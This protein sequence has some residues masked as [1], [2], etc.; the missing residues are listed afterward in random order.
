VHRWYQPGTGR[1]TRP[2]PL[3]FDRD[4]HP[5]VYGAGRP[6]F[7]FDP[8]GGSI[9]TIIKD[10]FPGKVCVDKDCNPPA[11]LARKG[12]YIPQLLPL[13]KCGECTTADGLYG[14]AGIWKIRNSGSCTIHCDS[15]GANVRVTCGRIPPPIL[16]PCKGGKQEKPDD[17]WPDNLFCH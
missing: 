10:L 14:R 5:Y 11:D 4:L 16:Y 15:N 2:D 7:F 17:T 9:K 8:D 6:T 1:Y 3:G 12:E 13:P